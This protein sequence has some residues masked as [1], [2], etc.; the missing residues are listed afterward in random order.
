M[1]NGERV[2]TEPDPESGVK[3]VPVDVRQLIKE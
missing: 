2:M 1:P 3:G